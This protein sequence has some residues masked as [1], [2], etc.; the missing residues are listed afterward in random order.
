M[1]LARALVSADPAPT[2]KDVIDAGEA[3]VTIEG[4]VD[5]IAYHELRA[6]VYAAGAAL[7][8]GH[9]PAAPHALMAVGA[10]PR[11]LRAGAEAE[12]R[13]CARYSKSDAA[14]WEYVDRAN[15]VRPMTWT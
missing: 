13:T 10:R 15:A 12:L 11:L 6:A 9:A 4:A 7:A 1:A 8:E 5:G 3:M 14:R 2:W